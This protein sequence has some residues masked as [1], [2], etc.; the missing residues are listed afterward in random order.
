MSYYTEL[1]KY[2]D[3]LLMYQRTQTISRSKK[4]EVNQLINLYEAESG[5]KVDKGCSNCLARALSRI[6]KRYF[7]LKEE[8]SKRRKGK[9]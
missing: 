6:C 2:E 5:I 1:K 3:I 9:E 7:Q 8:Y 4:E